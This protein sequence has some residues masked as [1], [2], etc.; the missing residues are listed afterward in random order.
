MPTPTENLTQFERH[1]LEQL[2]ASL[3]DPEP[4]WKKKARKVS[5]IEIIQAHRQSVAVTIK[6]EIKRQKDT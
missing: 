2:G 4:T 5:P 1:F 3:D 6:A